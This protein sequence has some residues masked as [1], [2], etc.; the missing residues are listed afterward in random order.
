MLNT[1]MYISQKDVFGLS[2]ASTIKSGW[3]YFTDDFFPVGAFETED[4]A[5]L[6]EDGYNSSMTN[7]RQS[8]AGYADWD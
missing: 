5:H 7:K 4:D 3:Y 8:A 6:A 1:V 2:P